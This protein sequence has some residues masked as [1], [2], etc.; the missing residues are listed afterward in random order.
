M[1]SLPK[2]QVTPKPSPPNTSCERIPLDTL[3]KQA[4]GSSSGSKSCS[5]QQPY[6]GCGGGGRGGGRTSSSR[7]NSHGQ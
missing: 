3:R 4:S 5:R 1:A 2:L 6:G 7:M